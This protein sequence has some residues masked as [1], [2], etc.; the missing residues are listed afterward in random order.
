M[1]AI[2]LDRHLHKNGGSTIR[3]VM[4]RNEEAGNCIYWGYGQ[5]REG[6]KSTMSLL[7]AL[8]GSEA[9]LPSLCIEA[10]AST[11][12]AIFVSHHLPQARQGTAGYGR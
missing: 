12:S 1:P 2:W 4:L 10:H 6:W 5:T 11:A 3:E 7:M 9:K 8:D